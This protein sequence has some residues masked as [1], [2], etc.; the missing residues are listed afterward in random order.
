MGKLL[1]P[2]SAVSLAL[3]C[4]IQSVDLCRASAA[5]FNFLTVRWP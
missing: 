2:A 4:D 3:L 1:W 5:V